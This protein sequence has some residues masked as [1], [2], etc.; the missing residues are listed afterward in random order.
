[1][2]VRDIQVCVKGSVVPN[3]DQKLRNLNILKVNSQNLSNLYY[4]FLS[5]QIEKDKCG[6]FM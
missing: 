5:D 3:Q 1:M 4:D 2:G 6:M